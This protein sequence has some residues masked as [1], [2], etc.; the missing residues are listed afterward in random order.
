MEINLKNLIQAKIQNGKVYLNVKIQAQSPKNELKEIMADGTLKIA[1]NALPIQGRANN[2]LLKFLS[3]EL[4]LP[5][6]QLSIE[7]GFTGSRK[8]IKIIF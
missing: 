5:I 7:Q 1:I 6:G 4:E 8:L 3:K 2:E